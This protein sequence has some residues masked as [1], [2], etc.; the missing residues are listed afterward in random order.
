MIKVTLPSGI[1]VEGDTAHEIGAVLR[2]ALTDTAPQPKDPKP[3]VPAQSN[4]VTFPHHIGNR[5]GIKIGARQ[6]QVLRAAKMVAEVAGNRTHEF[7]AQDICELLGVESSL[8]SSALN[9]LKKASVVRHGSH[10]R[11]WVVTAR[12][13]SGKY[14]VTQ[15]IRGNG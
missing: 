9:N 6:E 12:G 13:W 10:R 15:P 2:H 11:V 3:K 8:V 1:I 14:W 5:K 7:S 4:A